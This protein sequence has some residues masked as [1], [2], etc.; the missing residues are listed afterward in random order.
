MLLREFTGEEMRPLSRKYTE[1]VYGP[2]HSSLYDLSS[3]DTNEDNSVLEIV[4]F[5]S[6]IPVRNICFDPILTDRSMNMYRISLSQNPLGE[7]WI[8]T[9]MWCVHGGSEDF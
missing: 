7:S 1:W 4:V 3:I 5:G 2:V 9:V 8:F 6:E